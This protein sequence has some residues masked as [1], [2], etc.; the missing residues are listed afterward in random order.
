MKHIN[1]RKRIVQTLWLLAGVGTILL[2][3]AAMEKKKNKTCVDVKIEIANPDDQMFIDEKD[4]MDIINLNGNITQKN[5]SSVNLRILETALEKNPWVKNAEMFFDNNQV[6]HVDIE[7]R[8]PIARI[9]SVGGNS[10]Y[11]D[12]N[13]LRLPLSDKLS[14]RVPVFT[15]FPSDKANLSEP[16]SL[17]LE[18]VVQLGKFIVTDSFWMAQIAQVDITTKATFEIIPTIGNQT[19]A[20]G[21]A[22]DLENK[23]NRL[24]TFYKQAW[25][26]NGINTYEKL[27]VQF[28]NQVVAVRKGAAKAWIDSAKANQ[29]LIELMNLGKDSSN[30]VLKG[31]IKVIKPEAVK[32]V[33]DT[34]QNKVSNK[35]L[36]FGQVGQAVKTKKPLVQKT[37]PKAVMKKAQ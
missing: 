16:D 36:S 37:I 23:F 17:M 12:S 8:K 29:A 32:N 9:F 31:S 7:E 25:V 6:L 22:D 24:Y 5:I 10:F 28:D 2:F 30:S 18:Q 15:G 19:I 11:V 13:G 27:D 33:I 34:K 3:G 1:W 4:I 21:N 26:Q 20:I 14:A 35:S